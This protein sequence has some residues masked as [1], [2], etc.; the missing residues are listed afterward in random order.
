MRNE[1]HDKI[2]TDFQAFTFSGGGSMFRQ[3]IKGVG[4]DTTIDSG[5]IIIGFDQSTEE[6][7]GN[8]ST[9][10]NYGFVATYFEMIENRTEA[11]IDIISERI[12]NVEDKILDY[13]Q[14]EPPNITVDGLVIYKVRLGSI[15]PQIIET[16]A[17]IGNIVDF[18][19][20]VF[21]ELNPKLL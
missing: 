5:D 20:N 16:E 1:I 13:L 12:G 7:Y 15:L 2:I 11:E 14:K 3:V 17:G 18:R 4:S 9:I 6:I 21:V 8:S 19:F 10:R